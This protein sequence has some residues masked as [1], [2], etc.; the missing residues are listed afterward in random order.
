[1]KLSTKKDKLKK[2]YDE[3]ESLKF[4]GK[5]KTVVNSKMNDTDIKQRVRFQD[6]TCRTEISSKKKREIES[7]EYFLNMFRLR[8]A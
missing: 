4:W 2:V 5:S 3:V 1:M 8:E 6:T 7:Y